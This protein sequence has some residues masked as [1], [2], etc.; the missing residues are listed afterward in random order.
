MSIFTKSLEYKKLAKAFNGNY[1][2]LQSIIL[3]SENEGIKDDL[4]ILA[5][6]S[7]KE[8]MDRMEKY[9]WSMNNRISIPSMPGDKKTLIYAFNQTI[10]K[11]TE[12]AL[13]NDYSEEVEEILEK[14][15]LFFAIDES[16]PEHIKAKM[17]L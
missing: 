9:N 1:Q 17:K 2:M 8:I 4:N 13:L 12:L 10:G 16:I 7:R 6:L 11:M 15:S 5:Y 3:K 14:G